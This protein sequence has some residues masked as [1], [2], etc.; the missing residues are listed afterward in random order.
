MSQNSRR[1]VIALVLVLAVGLCALIL[2]WQLGGERISSGSGSSVVT[3]GGIGGD[4]ALTDQ[5]GRAVTQ[6]DYAGSFEL[7]YF[8]Y[9]FCPDVC[10]TELL[11]IAQTLD[12]LPAQTAERIQPI[13]ITID[14]E[15][16]TQ[17]VMADYVP[18]FYPRLVGLTGSPEQIATVAREFRVY[19]NKVPSKEGN[20]SD[21]LMDHS[22]FIYVMGRNGE[23]LDVIPYGTSKEDMVAKISQLVEKFGA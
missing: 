3:S 11:T 14:P 15:R 13:F 9:T 6:K 18:L 12:A 2:R 5:T 1:I 7:I 16:D 23:F 22:S 10:P 17:T 21:Y 8:G 20:A 4:F 19:Y